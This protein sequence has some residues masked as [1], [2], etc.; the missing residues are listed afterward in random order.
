MSAVEVNPGDEFVL[1]DGGINE[2]GIL[3][4]FRVI[5]VDATCKEDPHGVVVYRYF[6]DGQLPQ[7]KRC[8]FDT[9]VDHVL[10]GDFVR[11]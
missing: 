11:V 3:I 5:S 1:N 9:F 2:S 6:Q 7:T 8:R 4:R 10:A